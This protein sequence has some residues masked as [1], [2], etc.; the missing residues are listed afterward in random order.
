[1]S[2]PIQLAASVQQAARAAA[3]VRTEPQVE[4]AKETQTDN[5]AGNEPRERERE[6]RD[7]AAA[8]REARHLT[9]TRDPALKSFVYRSVD[10]E[11]GDVV[12]QYPAE[13]MLRHARHMKAM[14]EK[15]LAEAKEI[16]ETA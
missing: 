3:P 16:D 5:R 8:A 11:S 13:E 4:P 7:E 12:W 1:M 15:R 9:I 2:D 6:R 14:A 10:A